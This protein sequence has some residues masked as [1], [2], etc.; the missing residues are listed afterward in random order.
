MSTPSII[1]STFPIQPKNIDASRH[2][3]EAFNNM[4][5]EVSAGWIIRFAQHRDQSWEPFTY[6]DINDFYR[7]KHTDGFR[8]NRLV[9]P[10]MVP[11]SLARAFAGHHDQ[12]IPVGGGWLIKGDD[13]KYYF[14][15]DFVYNCFKSSPKSEAA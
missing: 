5:T 6:D 13:E 3:C 9:E 7:K 15:N 8:F 14:T 4:E 12:P 10:Q 1:D 2:L 11:P